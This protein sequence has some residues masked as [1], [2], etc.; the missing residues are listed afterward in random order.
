MCTYLWWFRREQY[1]WSFWLPDGGPT[2]EWYERVRTGSA[3]HKGAYDGDYH[4][5]TTET[6]MP[7][8]RPFIHWRHH[9]ARSGADVHMKAGAYDVV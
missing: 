1:A 9:S 2:E 3:K 7:I 4:F 6:A 5:V 8:S